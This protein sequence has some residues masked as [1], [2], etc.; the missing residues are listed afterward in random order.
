MLCSGVID[1]NPTLSKYLSVFVSYVAFACETV[2]TRRWIRDQSFC[3]GIGPQFRT[4]VACSFAAALWVMTVAKYTIF[5]R[6]PFPLT[7]H[8]RFE[9]QLQI[10]QGGQM[11]AAAH[12]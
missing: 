12:P 4:S 10:E 8:P 2:A 6:V 1:M 9:F 11:I 7:S 3:C 5:N